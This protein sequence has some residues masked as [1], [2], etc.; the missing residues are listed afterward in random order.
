MALSQNLKGAVHHH[1]RFRIDVKD[2][3]FQLGQ[4]GQRGNGKDHISQLAAIGTFTF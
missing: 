4:F 2:H 1:K 3:V